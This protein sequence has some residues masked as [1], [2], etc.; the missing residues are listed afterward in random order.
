VIPDAGHMIHHDRPDVVARIVE[1][2]LAGD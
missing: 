1:P 2:F